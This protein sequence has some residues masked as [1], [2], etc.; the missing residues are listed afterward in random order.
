MTITV[1]RV[2]GRIPDVWVYDIDGATSATS[3]RTSE[4]AVTAAKEA[5]RI[6]AERRTQAE[7]RA[8]Q[9]VADLLRDDVLACN[10]PEDDPDE[11][12]REGQPEFNGSFRFR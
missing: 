10:R 4:R 7:R 6:A 12:G 1:K 11:D 9:E 8:A 2:P 5:V 3:Y